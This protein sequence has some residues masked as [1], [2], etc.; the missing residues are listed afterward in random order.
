MKNHPV[1]LTFSLV[2]TL[3]FGAFK[4]GADKSANARSLNGGSYTSASGGLKPGEYACYGSGGQ[5]LI[6][7]GFKVLSGNRYTDL[8]NKEHGTFS[9]AGDT[10]T[11]RG[12]HLDSQVG[13]NLKD[14][15]FTIHS[16]SC[17]PFN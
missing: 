13:Q 4:Y 7:L 3:L 17:E 11:F 5:L 9:I 14:Y 16:A 15:K 12:G 1:L 2:L 10:V 6:G 8:D